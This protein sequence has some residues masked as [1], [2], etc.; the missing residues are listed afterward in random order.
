MTDR[1]HVRY[2]HAGIR[3]TLSAAGSLGDFY[4]ESAL[5]V[6]TSAQDLI[7]GYV[8]KFFSF[9]IKWS[10]RSLALHANLVSQKIG[11]EKLELKF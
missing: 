4:D 2:Q 1:W 5:K 9:H 7:L 10:A 3:T 8:L 6:G 11:T